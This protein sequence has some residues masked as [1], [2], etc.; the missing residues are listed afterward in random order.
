MVM[1]DR[2]GTLRLASCFRATSIESS[3]LLRKRSEAAFLHFFCNP[4]GIFPEYRADTY[5]NAKRY[6]AK[7]YRGQIFLGGFARLV[8]FRG[9]RCRRTDHVFRDGLRSLHAAG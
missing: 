9:C 3:D 5:F 2:F 6:Y 7:T 4:G 8:W 1:T